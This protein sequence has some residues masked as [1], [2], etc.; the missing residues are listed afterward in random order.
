MAFWRR[1]HPKSLKISGF[2]GEDWLLTSVISREALV[3]NYFCDLI[4][5]TCDLIS[6]NSDFKLITCALIYKDYD[7]IL[8][9]S[10]LKN[11]H[12]DF[13]MNVCELILFCCGVSL[14]LCAL[15]FEPYELNFL[16]RD[17]IILRELGSFS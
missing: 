9:Q 14:N 6:G 12:N 5:P 4:C 2:S 1:F 16:V 13:I 7:L 3:T 17:E 8:E 11:D 10:D 15:N